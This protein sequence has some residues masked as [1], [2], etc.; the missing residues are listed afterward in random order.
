MD[1]VVKRLNAIYVFV[2]SL[3]LGC[4]TAQDVTAT[5]GKFDYIQQLDPIDDTDN[6]LI[7]LMTQTTA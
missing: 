5:Y 1:G 4:V 7:L 2:I 3:F 6:N